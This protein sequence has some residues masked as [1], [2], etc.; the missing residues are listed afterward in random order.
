MKAK[1]A[2][3]QATPETTPDEIEK[4][5]PMYNGPLPRRAWIKTFLTTIPDNLRPKFADLK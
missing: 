3:A 4:L 1:E 5:I 2:A